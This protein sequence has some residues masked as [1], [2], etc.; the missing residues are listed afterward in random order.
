MRHFRVP[1]VSGYLIATWYAVILVA[2]RS[3]K[4]VAAVAVGVSNAR[5]TR[6]EMQDVAGGPPKDCAIMCK[7]SACHGKADP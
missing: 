2:V 7:K 4:A 6:Y 5:N 3:E 1:G